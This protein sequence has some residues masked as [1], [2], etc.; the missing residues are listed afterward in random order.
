ME[1]MNEVLEG[2]GI[3]TA[4]GL[5]IVGGKDDRYARLLQKFADRQAGT[6]EEIRTALAGGRQR[7]GGARG[8]FAQGLCRDAWY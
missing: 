5:R 1:L 6:V 2:A 8:A 3:D 4:A 7:D